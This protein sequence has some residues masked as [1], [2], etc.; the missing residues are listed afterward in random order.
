MSKEVFN[1]TAPFG[2]E[3]IK[4][5]IGKLAKQANGSC[6]CQV[7]GT[8]VLSACVAAEEPMEDVDFLPL[9]VDY[10]EKF[11]SSGKIPG[12]FFKREGRPSDEEMLRARLID[13]PIR[14]L[15]PENYFIDTQIFV[16]VLSMDLENLPD[17]PGVIASSIALLVSDINFT[18]P[19]SAVRVGRIEGKFVANPIAGDIEKSDLNLVVAGTKDGIVMVESGANELQES[20]MID[21]LK[22]AHEHIIQICNWQSEIAA[23]CGKTKKVS[24]APMFDSVILEKM[25]PLVPPYFDEINKIYDKKK[26]SEKSKE[27]RDQI[28]ATLI[29]EFPEK[30]KEIKRIFEHLYQKS[31]RDM[32]LNKGIRADGRDFTTIRPITSEVGLLPRTHGS[33]LFTRGQTQSLAV[34]TLGSIDDQ[35]TVDNIMG[36]TA[37]R[38]MLHYNFPSFSVGEVGPI[39]GPGRR[40]IGHGALAERA[41]EPMIP[42]KENFPYTIRV[43]SE[44]LESN[45][46]SS[47]A[48]VCAGTLSLMDAGVPIKKPVA[49]IA[50]GL[51]KEGDKY[52][53]LSDIIGLEDHLGDMD[54]KVA[55]TKDGI[56][57]LQMDIKIDNV[58]FEIME[59]ALAQAKEGRIFILNKMLETLSEP[60]P[61]LAPHAPRIT[62]MHI[63]TEKIREV[64]GPGGKVIRDIIDKTGV[65]IDIEDDGSVYICSV[66]KEGTDKAIE[67]ISLITAEVELHKIYKGKVVRITDFGAFVEILPGKDGL[68]HISELDYTRVGKVEDVCKVGDTLLVKVIE[69]D[70]TN[71]KV[72]L[73]RKQALR[74]TDPSSQQ[75]SKGGSS[76]SR[77]SSRD[78]R[79]SDR[80]YKK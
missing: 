28:I 9:T 62:V 53:V 43:V 42:D 57:A 78:R 36:E 54:F 46:S 65:K 29:P 5:Q 74:D 31:V 56:T 34:V 48:S 49:G 3:E 8:V 76:D 4:V 59:K 72:R 35:Q 41:I 77:D 37:K 14:P 70:P 73:S 2:I 26:R 6:L 50:M 13:R 16:T 17:I 20:E 71:G 47:M 22:F 44:I 60:R 75:F 33:A 10:R 64:I 27:I 63:N 55:G 18:K 45:G 1:F 39:R 51:V 38:F 7:G 24:D 40:E 67:M 68:V 21:A 30:E 52:V 25:I 58:N 15:F 19:V 23:K 80:P 79:N 12:G 11:Y 32:V 69:I 66:D 61:D